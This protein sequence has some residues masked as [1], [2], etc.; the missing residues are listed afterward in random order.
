MAHVAL[1]NKKHMFFGGG[2]NAD[3]PGGSWSTQPSTSAQIFT[4]CAF[5]PPNVLL[6]RVPL[7]MKFTS[8]DQTLE[9]GNFQTI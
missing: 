1:L 7:P 8:S 2:R 6:L 9:V 3:I 5:I 4:C